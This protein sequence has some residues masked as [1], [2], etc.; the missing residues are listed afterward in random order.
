[1]VS[2]QSAC[3]GKRYRDPITEYEGIATA[4]VEYLGGGRVQILLE[5]ARS[6]GNPQEHYFYESRLELVTPK[7]PMGIGS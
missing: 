1:V 4:R 5:R 2:D 7:P 6:D 3:L